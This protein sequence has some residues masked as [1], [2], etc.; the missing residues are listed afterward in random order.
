MGGASSAFFRCQGAVWIRFSFE[1][2]E[3][4][5][6]SWRCVLGGVHDSGVEAVGTD[7]TTER[8]LLRSQ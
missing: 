8:F 1:T 2:V 3:E 6:S 4:C 5:S 7:S